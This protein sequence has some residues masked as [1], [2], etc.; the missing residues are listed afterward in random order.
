MP[1]GGDCKQLISAVYEDTAAL[2]GARGAPGGWGPARY[3]D[4][5]GTGAAPRLPPALAWAARGA[6]HSGWGM[7]GFPPK[8][9]VT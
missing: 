8:R 3:P 4:G 2:R 5:E 7:R 9:H 1:R 6:S